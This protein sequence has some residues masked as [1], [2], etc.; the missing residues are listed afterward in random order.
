MPADRLV[1]PRLARLA[2][3]DEEQPGC[4]P[5]P[6]P[7]RLVQ[8]GGGEVAALAQQ[9]PPTPDYGHRIYHHPPVHRDVPRLERLQADSLG[10]PARPGSRTRVPGRP[11]R[12]PGGGHHKRGGDLPQ[13]AHHA[14]LQAT[15]RSTR[16]MWQGYYL[17]HDFAF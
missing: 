4:L 8:P 11:C 15:A 1:P 9:R 10:V 13:P 12:W 14:H 6:P 5:I 16:S 3:G 2:V 17:E 7:L